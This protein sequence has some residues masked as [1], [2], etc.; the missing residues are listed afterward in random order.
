MLILKITFRALRVNYGIS[1]TKG[2]KLLGVTRKTL[3]GYEYGIRK[4]NNAVIKRVMNIY[5]VP[6]RDIKF[7]NR[8]PFKDKIG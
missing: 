2:A 4:P 6:I 8:L 7:A 5:D 3:R 1:Q